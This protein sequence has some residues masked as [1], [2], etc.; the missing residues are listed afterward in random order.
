MLIWSDQSLLMKSDRDLRI[1]LNRNSREHGS[2]VEAG[3]IRYGEMR[4]R[5]VTTW[6][7]FRLITPYLLPAWMD[8]CR[9]R[10]QKR[11]KSRESL[12]LP[13]ILRAAR[14]NATRKARLQEY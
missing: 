11:W 14:S 3:I 5:A 10:I 12:T 9:W 6:I 1:G 8:T 13:L 7:L 2:S 4:G